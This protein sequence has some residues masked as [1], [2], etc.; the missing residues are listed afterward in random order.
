MPAISL[1]FIFVQALISVFVFAGAKQYGSRSPLVAGLTMFALGI[2]LIYVLNT[3]SQL[4]VVE[5]L[6]ALA[7]FAGQ[8]DNRQSSIA[9]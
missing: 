1:I 2:V 5:T 8:R 4:L 9:T 7:Y 6:I 3:V